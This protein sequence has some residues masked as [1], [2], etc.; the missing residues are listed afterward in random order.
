MKEGRQEKKK[1]LMIQNP[2]AGSLAHDRLKI[3]AE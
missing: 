1:D 3:K 2:L